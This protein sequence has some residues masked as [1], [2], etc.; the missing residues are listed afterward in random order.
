MGFAGGA[1]IIVTTFPRAYALPAVL[2]E[3]RS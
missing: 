1:A 3:P 2:E